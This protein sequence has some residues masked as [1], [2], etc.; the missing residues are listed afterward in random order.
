VWLNA[1]VL[2][3]VTSTSVTWLGYGYDTTDQPNPDIVPIEL[4]Y[5]NGDFGPIP[6]DIQTSINRS[7]AA[8][9]TFRPGDGP[10]LTA[11]DLAQIAAADPFSV[12]TYGTSYIGSSPPSPQ[13]AD[14]RF[15]LSACSSNGSSDP[16][17]NYI[18]A[19]PSQGA[20]VDTCTLTYSN[21]STT[22]QDIT[23]SYSQTFSVD[24]SISAT[25]YAAI[26][27]DLKTAYTLTWTTEA[28]SSITNTTS[29]TAMLSVQGP[30]CNNTSAGVGPCVPVYDSAGGQPV[31]FEVY[32]D[33]LYGTFMFAPI[34]F[35]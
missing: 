18:Q 21:L 20:A 5:L 28:Q 9:Q 1:A 3:D 30:P 10:A 12:S 6:P 4:G 17:F 27:N 19:A 13:T 29:S 7:W 34:N 33:N 16:S 35:Y 2:F 31:Q 8:S 22:S 11:A 14:S 32:Q 25:F 26:S 23:N 24:E 15:T